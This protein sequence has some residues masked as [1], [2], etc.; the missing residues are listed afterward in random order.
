[1][2][3]NLPRNTEK[4]LWIQ[5]GFKGGLL[6]K[7]LNP[8]RGPFLGDSVRILGCISEFWSVT[9]TFG[10][11]SDILFP[12]QKPLSSTPLRPHPTDPKRTQTDPN[13]PETDRNGPET[14]RNRALWGGTAGGFVGRGGGGGCNGKRKITTLKRNFVQKTRK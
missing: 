5:E 4:V 3:R 12:L 8:I 2:I 10:L 6:L 7:H 13:G 11:N 1:M 14:D 9:P